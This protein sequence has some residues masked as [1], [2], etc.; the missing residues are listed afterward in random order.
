MSAIFELARKSLVSNFRPLQFPMKLS[1]MLTYNCNAKCLTC[2]IWQV[3]DHSRDL[4]F[5]E[6]DRLFTK[7]NNFSWID[8]T[9]GEIFLRKD[10]LDISHLILDRCK[11]LYLFHFA[12]NGFVQERTVQTV[13]AILNRKPKKFLVTVSLDG[14][15][16]H[17]DKIRG[18]P[19]GFEK[20]LD[21]YRELRKFNDNRFHV[22]LGMTLSDHNHDQFQKTYEAVR[23]VIPQVSYDDFHVN[24]AQT[25]EHFYKN[26]EMEV[27]RLQ[28]ILNTVREVKKRQ[29]GNMFSPVRYLEGKY[30]DLA[31]RYLET[32]RTPLPCLSL[33]V[34]CFVGPYGDVYPCHM[35]D[36]VIGNIRDHD[37]DLK[38]IWQD[39]ETAQE[40]EKILDGQCPHCW[41]PCEAYQ[42]IIGNVLGQRNT[43][44]NNGSQSIN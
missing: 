37:Y 38:K 42:T 34:S 9:G 21:T 13:E 35:Y 5:E 18:V 23:D 3:K 11:N 41:T 15:K 28:E 22:F 40:R 14:D 36:K 39:Y 26:P 4:T 31:G 25:S 29:G 30:Q 1:L 27:H 24:I 33:S 16:E 44:G 8:L 17:H 10:I 20:T 2:N 32:G 19:N 7:S 12:T 43:N 6:L